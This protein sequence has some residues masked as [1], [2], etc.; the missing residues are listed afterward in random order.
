MRRR[1]ILK[2]IAGAFLF[3]SVEIK[4]KRKLK[5]YWSEESQYDL[6]AWH[7]LEAEQELSGIMSNK[8]MRT[9]CL[10]SK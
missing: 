5:A 9:I 6:R 4:P 1:T 8:T 7:N 3:P 10:N 2:C